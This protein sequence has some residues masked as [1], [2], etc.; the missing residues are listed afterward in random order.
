MKILSDCLHSPQQPEIFPN[1]VKQKFFLQ[2]LF[3]QRPSLLLP[4][5]YHSAV[6]LS[7]ASAM[8]LIYSTAVLRE[9][10]VPRAEEL[11][12]LQQA[13]GGLHLPSVQLDIGKGRDARLSDQAHSCRSPSLGSRL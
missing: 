10:A 11:L 7:A 6:A 12:A 1:E 8:L 9:S 5:L 2:Q 13:G 4:S 3:L